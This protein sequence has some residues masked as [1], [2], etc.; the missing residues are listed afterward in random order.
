MDKE[1]L[2]IENQVIINRYLER[3]RIFGYNNKT[4][5]WYKNRQRIRFKDLF[6]NYDFKDKS[7]LDVGNGL[8]D[9][10]DF[11][12]EQTMNFKYT[13]ID[14]VNEFVNYSSE[15]FKHYKDCSIILGDFLT[16]NFLEKYDVVFGSGL[17]NQKYDNFDNYEYVNIL[18]KKAYDLSNN[19]I[20]FDFLSSNVDFMTSHNFYY[21]PEK[22][23]EMASRISRR[24]I[25]NH[26]YL[27][28]EFS[29]TIFI[30][31]QIDNDL[32]IYKFPSSVSYE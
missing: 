7:I 31:N 18:L 15:K 4:L 22:I 23:Y 16:Y 25:L 26:G 27:P 1:K 17:F 12:S 5:G 11:I 32:G 14:L 28:W 30:V 19:F 29:I 6:G 10:H 8:S 21:E 3:L 24:V 13:G 9:Y 2:E 20:V